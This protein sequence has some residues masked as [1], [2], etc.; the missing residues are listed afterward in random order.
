MQ[1]VADLAQQH[2]AMVNGEGTALPLQA[3]IKNEV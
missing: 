3:T 1:Q 2:E